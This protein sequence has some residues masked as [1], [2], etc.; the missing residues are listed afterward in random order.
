MS[1]CQPVHRAACKG[2]MPRV[3][4]GFFGAGIF[5]SAG[6][7]ASMELTVFSSSARMAPKNA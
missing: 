6:S 1:R 7:A 3:L 5:T 4:A 2:D